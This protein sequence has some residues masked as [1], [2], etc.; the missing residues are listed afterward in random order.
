MGS[1]PD[2]R[3]H[4]DEEA[5]RE[6]TLKQPFCMANT[7]VSQQDFISIMG[8]NPSFFSACG[9]DCPVHSVTWHEA[10]AY[11]NIRSH[12][13]EVP[14]CYDCVG[15][16]GQVA[17]TPRGASPYDCR[18]YRLPTEAEWEYAA[19]A[20]STT[21]LPTGNLTHLWCDPLDPKADALAWYC[22]NAEV[23]YH[24]CIDA[25][26]WN[27]PK[28]S[29]VRPGA[30]K[31]PNPWGLFDMHGN[32]WEWVHDWYGPYDLSDTVDP[33]GPATG[34]HKVQRGGSWAYTASDTRSA[35]RGSDLPSENFKTPGFRPVIML[36]P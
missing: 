27:G 8:Y 33:H 24:G 10:A 20:G 13:E 34:T 14:L 21:A 12:Q 32:V 25:T 31:A 16:Y 7:E 5:Q 19:R 30:E 28:C 26:E 9:D 15:T 35:A 6:V 36:H 2:E 4:K 23:T 1:H 29:G 18:G 11:C 22:G 17:C 3:G